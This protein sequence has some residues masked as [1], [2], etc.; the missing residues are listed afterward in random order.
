MVLYAYR[1]MHKKKSTSTKQTL[2]CRI[3][4]TLLPEVK[5]RAAALGQSPAVWVE[6]LVLDALG[7]DSGS[8]ASIERRLQSL[9]LWRSAVAG[10]GSGEGYRSR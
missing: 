5:Q 1:L 10:A 2:S 7:E 6:N 8:V 3:D 4:P 9:E